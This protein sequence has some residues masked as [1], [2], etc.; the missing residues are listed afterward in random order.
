M[1]RIATLMSGRRSLGTY[2]LFDAGSGL[3][4]MPFGAEPLDEFAMVGPPRINWK[5]V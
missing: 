5:L 4:V 2:I 3:S 1:A